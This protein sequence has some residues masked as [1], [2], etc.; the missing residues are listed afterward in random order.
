MKKRLS[1]FVGTFLLFTS[2]KAGFMD[3]F[4]HNDPRATAMLFAGAAAT[5]TGLYLLCKQTSKRFDK[6]ANQFCGT[7]L[8]AT[9]IGLILGSS[10]LV[11]GFDKLIKTISE[12]N[13]H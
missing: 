2:A 11:A 3:Q 10:H 6:I 9:G 12:N 7:G 5:G 8:I 4:S 1:L 13:K